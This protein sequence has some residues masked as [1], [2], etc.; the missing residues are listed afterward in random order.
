MPL[1]LPPAIQA[2]EPPRTDFRAVAAL[3]ES[4][5]RAGRF[6]GVALVAKGDQVLFEQAS[7]LALRAESLPITRN[8]RFQ[9]ASLGKLFTTVAIGQLIEGGKVALEDPITK[10]LPE[11]AGHPG[12]SKVKVRHLLAHTSGFGTYWGPDFEAR[13]TSLRAV[14][15]YF[16][17]FEKAPLA[18]EPGTKWAYSN[19]GFILLGAIV[20]R[21]SGEDYFAYVQK[22]VFEAAGMKDSGYFEADEDL[23]RM[24]TGYTHEWGPEGDPMPGP[25][26]THV[27]IKP[28]KGSPAGDSISTAPDLLRFARGLLQGRLLR[29][30]TF[31]LLRAPVS[32]FP[33]RPGSGI[34]DHYGLGFALLEDDRGWLVG[35]TG[36]FPGTTTS[37]FMDPASGLVCLLLSNVDGA[38]AAPVDSLLQGALPR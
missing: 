19:V 6:G 5:A 3:M 32:D 8:T 26:R 28:F 33:R 27:Q 29:P 14:K 22:H 13:R 37:L 7:G 25:A 4:E 17:L 1:P 23:P 10:H 36:G 9:L 34:T 20:E 35:H 24:A 2:P 15:D 30:E 16:P 18:F 12:W 31:A 21:A 11:Y 38:R